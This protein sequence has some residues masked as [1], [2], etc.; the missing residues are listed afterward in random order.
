MIDFNAY[1]A[2][3]ATGGWHG[4][5]A[6]RKCGRPGMAGSVTEAQSHDEGRGGRSVTGLYESVTGILNKSVHV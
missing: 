2:A 5:L 1:W 3:L 6:R 4:L